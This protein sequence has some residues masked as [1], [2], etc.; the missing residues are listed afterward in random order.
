MGNVR[1]RGRLGDHPHVAKRSAPEASCS[2][3]ER[4]GEAAG[5][6][7]RSLTATGTK[8]LEGPRLAPLWSNRTMGRDCLTQGHDDGYGIKYAE[9]R[10]SRVM[11]VDHC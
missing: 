11:F 7:K 2:V 9:I 5:S 6:A 1:E 3:S 4:W 8:S 10:V